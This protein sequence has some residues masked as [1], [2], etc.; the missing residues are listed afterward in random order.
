MTEGLD[1]VIHDLELRNSP[2]YHMLLEDMRNLLVYN[3]VIDVDVDGQREILRSGGRYHDLRGEDGELLGRGIP[4][5]P[6][7]TG[8]CAGQARPGCGEPGNM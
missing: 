3:I 1:T 6:L 5:F 2:Q 8:G 4:T 7:N